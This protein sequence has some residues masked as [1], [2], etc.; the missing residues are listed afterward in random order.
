MI[1]DTL[2]DRKLFHKI[3]SK[4]DMFDELPFYD[5]AVF[6][7]WDPSKSDVKLNKK[8]IKD[9]LGKTDL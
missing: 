1:I 6:Y 9:I 4:I 5:K 8:H 3:E 7:E 2:K